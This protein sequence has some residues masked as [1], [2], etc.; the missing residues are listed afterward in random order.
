MFERCLYFNINALARA[1]NHRWEDAYQS[2]GLSPAHAYLLRLVLKTPGIT[3]K[4]LAAELHLAPSTITR[5]I[6]VLATRGLLQRQ[7]T[8]GDGREWAIHP[9]E[10][11]RALHDE[12]ERISAGL[13]QELR[14][15]LGDARCTDLVSSLRQVHK[16]LYPANR[17]KRSQP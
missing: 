10:T 14:G 13:F 8:Q 12:L 2:V 9:T 16:T 5:F 7:D 6:D 17:K 4:Q 15:T 11:A 3:Q 1:I